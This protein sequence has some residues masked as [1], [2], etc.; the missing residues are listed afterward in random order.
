MVA[1]APVS[2]RCLP[3]PQLWPVLPLETLGEGGTQFPSV[4]T[5]RE[6]PSTPAGGHP[7]SCL[8]VSQSC[9]GGTAC[10]LIQ[11]KQGGGLCGFQISSCR[12]PDSGCTVS[13]KEEAAA[14]PPGVCRVQVS[15]TPGSGI[16]GRLVL[17]KGGYW[18]FPGGPVVRT[19]DFH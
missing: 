3:C 4:P 2:G 1:L 10:G 17:K 14:C 8:A 19:T 6:G 13:G 18:A 11:R 9:L 5:G 15:T 16:W 12:A 7:L